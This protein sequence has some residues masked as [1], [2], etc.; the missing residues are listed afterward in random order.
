[1]LQTV[2][3][4]LLIYELFCIISM[5]KLYLLYH[6]HFE[7]MYGHIDSVKEGLQLLNDR[8]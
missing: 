6:L 1:M 8:H 3:D 5:A 2:T 4:E 7:E